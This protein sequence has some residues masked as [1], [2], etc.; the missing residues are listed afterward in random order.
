MI[1][2]LGHAVRLRTQLGDQRVSRLMVGDAGAIVTRR[3][4][5][6]HRRDRHPARGVRALANAHEHGV[7]HRDIKPD[8][9]L[10]SGGSAMVT[11]FDVAKVLTAARLARLAAVSY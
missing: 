10:L 9:V 8:K 6:G 5:A 2:I 7:V 1:E 3:R 11:D 4:T